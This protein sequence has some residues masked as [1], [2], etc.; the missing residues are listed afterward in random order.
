MTENPNPEDEGIEFNVTVDPD[1]SPMEFEY[2]FT[3]KGNGEVGVE[4][5]DKF[6]VNKAFGG[7]DG[8]LMAQVGL[9]MAKMGFQFMGH[10]P[11]QSRLYCALALQ[12]LADR[13]TDDD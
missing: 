7:G 6:V 12:S 9:S 4:I 1:S 10:T 2:R 3:N 5:G 11:E 8:G 13:F